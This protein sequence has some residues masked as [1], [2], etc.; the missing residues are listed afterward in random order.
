MNTIGFV[1]I[2]LIISFSFTNTL[3]CSTPIDCY[4]KAVDAINR[5]RQ[6]MRN[7]EDSVNKQTE[8]IKT[9]FDT[10][11]VEK[12]KILEEGLDFSLKKILSLEL[13]ISQMK[14][15][16]ADRHY[17]YKEA[18]IYQDIFEAL[19][20]GV[21]SKYGSPFGWDELSYRVNEW[22]SR[23]MLKI[24]N[25]PQTNGNGL[26]VKIPEGFNNIWVR[27]TNDR[28]NIFRIAALEDPSDSVEKY[29]CFARSLNEISPDGSTSDT[30]WNVHK[31][32]PMPI[33]KKGDYIIYT[34]RDTEGWI[35]GIA[36]GKNLWNHAKNGGLAY[37]WNINGGTPTEWSQGG[38]N[39]NN[40]YL[41][42]FDQSK[43]H[44][45]KVP[46]VPSGKDKL[47][48]LIEHN[49]NWEGTMHTGLWVNNQPIDRFRTSFQNPFAVHY[50]SKIYQRYLAAKIPKELINI[51]D[52]FINLRVDMTRSNAAINFRELGTH[53]W[54]E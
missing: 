20:L 27:V 47:V 39:W 4:A 7:F 2:T 32:C 21:I 15:N 36:F 54:F 16:N 40:D 46:V 37:V 11:F 28:T 19:E 43:V 49:N 44:D 45:I 53:D 52:K 6:E 25:G 13:E 3:D 5:D 8:E 38:N 1:T 10:E 29:A 12:L 48:Y 22:N 18:L 33:H 41:T 14:K 51:D 34:D 9:K 31:W 24:G 30:Y 26:K 42:R 50:N 35:S 17:M 23:K